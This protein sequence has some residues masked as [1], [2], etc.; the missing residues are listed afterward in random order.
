MSTAKIDNLYIA[1]TS[2]TPLVDFRF[3]Q[4]QLRLEGESYPENAAAFYGPLIDQTK[5]Y[6]AGRGVGD[7]VEMHVD[8]SYFN[9]SS[10]KML[11]SLFDLLNQGADRG[12]DIALHWYHDREDDIAEEFGQELRIDFPSL[13]FH[14]HPTD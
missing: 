10:T 6:V 8:L 11:F 1:G 2:S 3:D 13:T 5:N 4:H 7:D 12:V 9:S 14:A